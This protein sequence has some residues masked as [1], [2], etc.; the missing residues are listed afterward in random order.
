VT[1]LICIHRADLGW[2]KIE[3]DGVR[4]VGPR[5]L[6]KLLRK[7]PVL[8]TPDGVTRLADQIDRSLAPAVGV[9]AM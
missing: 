8:L 3:V 2:F 5:E 7:A 4:I 1:P 6:V 9:R